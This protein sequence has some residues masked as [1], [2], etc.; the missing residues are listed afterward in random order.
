MRFVVNSELNGSDLG[1]STFSLFPSVKHKYRLVW[2]DGRSTLQSIW[3]EV[4]IRLIIK[5]HVVHFVHQMDGKHLVQLFQ[6]MKRSFEPVKLEF[7]QIALYSSI[8]DVD[9]Y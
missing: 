2:M 7:S 5:D 8:P 9:M 6:G 4:E 3:N 1:R